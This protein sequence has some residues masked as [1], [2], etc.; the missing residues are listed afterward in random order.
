VTAPGS[1]RVR[2]A[3]IGVAAS[4]ALNL[5]LLAFAG[6]QAWRL[7]RSGSLLALSTSSDFVSGVLAERLLRRITSV[8]PPADG[9]L[10]HAAFAPRMPEVIGLGR[11]AFLAVERAREDIGAKHLD[12]DKVKADLAAAN[13]ARQAIRPIVQGTLLD[14]LPRMSAQ[15]RLALSQYRVLPRR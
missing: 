7:T 13:D 1:R 4:I 12:L 6:G 5:F 10:V 3:R 9:R 2:W 8:L 11:R 15:G 14:V